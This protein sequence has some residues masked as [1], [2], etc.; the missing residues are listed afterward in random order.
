[1]PINSEPELFCMNI[2]S[3][4]FVVLSPKLR[5]ASLDKLL[6]CRVRERKYLSCE[7]ARYS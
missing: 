2:I 5:L 4:G 1:M 6:S 7:E 3:S